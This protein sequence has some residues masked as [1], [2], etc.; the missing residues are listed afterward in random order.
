[1]QSFINSREVSID[2]LRFL[3]LSLIILAHVQPPELLFQIRAFDVPLM[4]FVSGLAFSGRQPDFSGKFFWKRLKRLVV[5]VYI[6]LTAYFICVYIARMFGV[7]FGVRHQHII[8]S[9][10]LMDGI[11]YV[12][13]IRVFLL[14]GVLT[15]FFLAFDKKIQSD[16]LFFSIW[17]IMIVALELLLANQLGRHITF[18]RE[19]VYYAVGYGLIFMLGLRFKRLKRGTKILA[20]AIIAVGYAA[21]QIYNNQIFTNNGTYITVNNFKYPPRALFLLY[22]ATLSFVSIF[23]ANKLLK[24]VHIPSWIIFIGQNTIW[25]YLYHIPLIQ[26]TGMMHLT[27]GMRFFSVY[28]IATLIVFLQNIVVFRFKFPFHEYFVG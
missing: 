28:A 20:F 17:G 9:Y 12:W 2:L 11:G 25:I 4:L 21:L 24:R 15:P 7:D 16:S 22:G 19:F 3:G 8:G 14:V 5:P 10:L 23:I 6:F 27:W 26:L 13:V 18:V 1:M